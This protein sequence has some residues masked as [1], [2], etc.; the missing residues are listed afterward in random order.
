MILKN[1]LFSIK[2]K[3]IVDNV[4]TYIIHLIPDCFIYK[5]H[6]PEIPITPG[7]CII[8]MVKE[9]LEDVVEKKLSISCISN[10]K[11][12]SVMQPEGQ[13]IKVILSKIKENEGVF[14]V[15]S[16][17]SEENGVNYAKI[18]IQAVVA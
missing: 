3:Q 14:A 5:A 1:N 4:Y 10:A 2:E 9:L 8:Q 18:S 15:Q 6:F 13:T 12:L 16:L 17:V 7:V 11:F